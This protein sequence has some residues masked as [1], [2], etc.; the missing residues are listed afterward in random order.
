MSKVFREKSL[1]V[2]KVKTFHSHFRAGRERRLTSIGIRIRGKGNSFL[3][4]LLKALKYVLNVHSI[5]GMEF[6]I[7]IAFLVLW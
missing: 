2:W 4:L 6:E 7:I 3:F 1:L 5:L